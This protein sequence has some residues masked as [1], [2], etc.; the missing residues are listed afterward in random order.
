[1]YY[2]RYKLFKSRINNGIDAIE[3]KGDYYPFVRS[4]LDE[5]YS[6]VVISSAVMLDILEKMFIN[7]Q[8]RI[9]TI[10]L[11]EEDDQYEQ[12]I[13]QL[14]AS[15]VKDRAYFYNLMKELSFLSKNESIEIKSIRVQYR[16]EEKP[17]DIKLSVNGLINVGENEKI[18]NEISF[19]EEI[20]LENIPC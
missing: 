10:E 18:K 12:Q 4:K 2:K 16:L 13:Q 15:T 17:I 8:A 9:V 14:I 19:L 5:G 1:M 3:I 11:I 7:K 20:I 6:Q